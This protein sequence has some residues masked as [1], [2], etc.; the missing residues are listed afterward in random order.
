M[1]TKKV[2][3]SISVRFEGKSGKGKL[4][5][6]LLNQSL[7]AGDF[8][9]AQIISKKVA[10]T[11]VK[12]NT[13]LTHQSNIDND[14]Y[15]ILSGAISIQVNGREVATRQS[16]DH[17]GEMALVDSTALRSAS[18]IAVDD[19]V[20]AKLSEIDFTKIAI[21]HPE[22][23]RRVAVIL[24][25]RLRDRNKF[26][27]APRSQPSIFIGSSKEGLKIGECIYDYLVKLPMVPRIWSQGVFE[28]SKTAIENLVSLTKEVD[29]AIIILT[30]D[31]ITSSRG[32]KKESP[33][34]NAI[35]ELGLFMGAIG[36]ERTYILSPSGID[37]KIP[38][39]LVGVTRLVY[40]NKG[41]ISLPKKLRT[42][43]NHIRTLINKLGPI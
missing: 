9:L 11:E 25:K 41:R 8:R 10:I 39:D 2:N 27:L 23:W 22:I 29:F 1:S 18:L 5:D 14:I 12:K 28:A 15:F 16:G 40:Q 36:R 7:V 21:Q 26:H 6:A 3:P 24:A 17:V 37:I 33:R 38:T 35:F 43:K 30:P 4:I 13:Y 31:D 20:V 32:S 42:V 19:S 34:D